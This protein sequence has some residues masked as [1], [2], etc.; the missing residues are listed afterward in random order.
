MNQ[1]SSLLAI[2]KA[3]VIAAGVLVSLT[4]VVGGVL[5]LFKLL[6]ADITGAV[7]GASCL[8]LGLG[9]G[10]ALIWQGRNAWTRRMS[11]LFRPPPF[12]LILLLY[13]PVIVVGQLVITFQLWPVL[14]LPLFHFLA[15]AIPPAAVLAFAGR[16][17][18]AA[19]IRW[20]EVIL[21]IA[22][23]AFLATT[24]AITAEIILGF[25]AFLLVMV[26]TALMPGGI[27]MVEA[28]TTNLRDPTWLENPNNILTLLTSPPVLIT[29]VIVF[30]ILAPL[31]EELLKPVG[32]IVMSSYR[33]PTRRQAFLWGLACGAG[34]TLIEN[35]F[36]T[37]TALDVWAFVMVLR[38]GGTV[39]HCLGS[40]LIALG[41]QRLLSER[42]P[43]KL[44]GAYGLSV[45][46]HALWNIAAIGIAGTSLWTTDSTN[47]LTQT[48]GSGVT[49]LLLVL[50]TGLAL[51]LIG[52]LAVLTYRL[53]AT[54]PETTSA[55]VIS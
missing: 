8:T 32:V 51:A 36:N 29:L 19:N 38:I 23:G 49:V 11:A 3:A 5:Y 52:T 53:R 18:R 31:I 41:W 14:T 4:G 10:A 15:A 2:S 12:W 37:V 17:F 54:P 46:I 33:R 1:D 25:M 50:L 42:R 39:M 47:D 6:S 24:L 20:R 43:W 35:L 21:Q 27:A 55:E 40:G 26:I 30:A 7:M 44:I 48:L 45:T 34:F 28:L 9:M 16:A 22:S 13:L